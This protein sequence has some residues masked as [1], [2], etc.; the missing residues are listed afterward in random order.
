MGKSTVAADVRARRRAAVRRRRRGSPAAGPGRRAGRRR[1]A[2]RFPGSGARRRRSTA[3]RC[4]ALVL[5]DPDELAA[6]EAIVHP[7]CRRRASGSSPDMRDAP[8]LLFDIPLL[9]ETGGEGAFDKVIVVSAPAEVQRA[10]R[11]RAAGHD[12][13]KS[14]TRSSPARCPTRRS[15]RRADFVVDTGGRLVRN[16]APGR[17]HSR[18]SRTRRGWITRPC[19]KSSSIP[20]PPGSIRPAATA[21]SRSAASR[22]STG[23]RPAATST[24]ISIPSGRCRARPRRSTG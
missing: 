16:R 9:F 7:R 6:L 8:A 1:S 23:S 19:G 18:L 15:A 4:R 14:S 17:R 21:W 12:G 22:C 24:L 3:R 5:G 13:R 11:A 2:E 10:A 20:R